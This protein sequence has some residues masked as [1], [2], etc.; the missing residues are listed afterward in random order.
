MLGKGVWRVEVADRGGTNAVGTVP[1][2]ERIVVDRVRDDV[3]KAAL[4][5]APLTDSCRRML[6]DVHPGRHEIVL[7]RDA[8][9]V[10]EGPITRLSLSSS[11]V[12]ID[13][14][15]VVWYLS[16][17]ALA[18]DYNFTGRRQNT[19][20]FLRDMVNAHGA[21]DFNFNAVHIASAD[22]VAT[23][24]KWNR[25][26]RTVFEVLDKYAEDSG[27]DYVVIGR[28][29][30]IY[31][32]HT[33]VHVL[34]LLTQAAFSSD[35]ALVEYGSGLAT[36]SVVTNGSEYS[37]AIADSKWLDYYGLLD[38]VSTN[39]QEG[40]GAADQGEADEAREEQS[41][42]TLINMVPA[43][44]D[45]LVPANSSFDPCAPVDFPDLHPG[46]WAQID[47][48]VG[49]RRVVQWQRVDSIRVTVEGGSEDVA[50][51]FSQPP[52]RWVDPI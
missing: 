2:V 12:E 47:A 30:Y 29:I 15:D 32:T 36:R 52:V 37:F 43:P 9:R 8:V 44:L 28:T 10:W 33:R 14:A 19:C 41:E 51:S 7:Y 42:R 13:A 20:V 18:F 4:R 11:V 5:V 26:S 22:D 3:S 6:A 35:L 46:A 1:D 24:A 31:D 34:P 16:R 23:A 38:H 39:I 25:Y 40:Q 48:E 45:V 50:V 49:F 21:S 17:R 27:I